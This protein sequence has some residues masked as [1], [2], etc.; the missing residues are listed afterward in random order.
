[1]DLTTN[2]DNYNQMLPNST[3]G[4]ISVDIK[5]AQPLA[6][7]QQLVFVGEFRNQLAIRYKTAACSKYDF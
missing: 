1:M 5:Y 3:S 6:A 2:K 7:A 4:V